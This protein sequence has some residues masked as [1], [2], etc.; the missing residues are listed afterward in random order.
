MS[1]PYDKILI[2]DIFSTNLENLINVIL[3]LLLKYSCVR[4]YTTIIYFIIPQN[5][6]HQ[7]EAFESESIFLFRSTYNVYV[8]H[9][10]ILHIHTHTRD[11]AAGRGREK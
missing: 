6:H 2:C 10:H 5:H 7:R 3:H 11:K 1:T 8:S 9:Y 4:K